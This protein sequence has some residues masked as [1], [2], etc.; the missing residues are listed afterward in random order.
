MRRIGIEERRARLAVR[1]HLS[2]PAPGVVE[3][4]AGVVALHGTDA[5]SVY[6]SAAAR[7][8]A[9]SLE[10]IDAALYADR[11]LVRILGMRRT[12]FVPPIELAPVVQAACTDA[13]AVKERRRFVA[14]L[15]EAGID[16]GRHAN[17]ADWL[18]DVGE[19]AVRALRA[20]GEALSVELS[21]EEPRLRTR[22][23]MAPG[24]SYEST[25]SVAGRLLPILAA[26]GRIVR[27]RPRGSWLS[28]RYQWAPAEAWLPAGAG[29]TWD[30]ASAQAELVRR[31]LARFGPG[32]LADLKWWTGLTVGEVKRALTAVR[33]VEVD[34][35]GTTGFVLAEDA[36]PVPAPEPWVALLPALDPTPMGWTERD[37]YLGE[38]RAALF[39]RSGNIGPTVW[40]D[41]RIVGGWAQRKDGEIAVRLLEDIGDRAKEVTAAA[42]GL[43]DRLGPARFVPK[44]R[45]PLEREL[46]E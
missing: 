20:R 39:D 41:G 36:D 23:V 43:A 35:G 32:T 8:H 25:V 15:T 17:V 14:A 28:T 19:S 16:I 34:L 29:T 46:T 27:G 31:W 9:P 7:M 45:T 3:A 10:T 30:A 40:C 12:I 11:S 4:A 1:H 2:G 6:L 21:A 5:A 24:K 33:P 18:A 26:E 13:I 37:W 44:F 38:H 42:E 22:L